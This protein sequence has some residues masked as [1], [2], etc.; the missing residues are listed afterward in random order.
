MLQA[1]LLDLDDTLLG[2]DIN[3]FLG[4]YFPL[5]ARHMSH[6]M[7]PE[8]FVRHLLSSTQV[9]M[10]DGDPERTNQD[11]FWADFCA[12]TGLERDALEPTIDAFYRTEFSNLRRATERRPEAAELVQ[13]CFEAGFKVAIATNPVFPREAINQRLEWAG[14]GVGDFAYELVT[15][16]ENM[17]ATKPSTRYYQEILTVL[18]VAPEHGL[19]VGDDWENDIIPASKL[20][21]ATF[22]V[23][24][25][26]VRAPDQTDAVVDAQGSL[27]DLLSLMKS[28]WLQSAREN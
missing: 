9:M 16:Y 19:M 25:Q 8:E 1:V 23:A 17:H 24:D 5:V 14:V 2:N 12:R 11:V 20:G 10:T 3:Q 26:E 22:W 27:A 21:L 28:G 6:L 15:A 13:Y 18:D 4:R 7:E